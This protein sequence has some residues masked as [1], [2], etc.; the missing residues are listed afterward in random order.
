MVLGPGAARIVG[1]DPRGACRGPDGRRRC[2]PVL[3]L[4]LLPAA[5]VLQSMPRPGGAVV[6]GRAVQ[7]GS[8]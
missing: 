7:V 2:A 6:K 4:S 1:G 5:A 3:R 8:G